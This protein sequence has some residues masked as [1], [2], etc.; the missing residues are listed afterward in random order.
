MQRC[1]EL[2]RILI[3]I[4]RLHYEEYFSGNGYYYTQDQPGY[5]ITLLRKFPRSRASAG[6]GQTQ[7]G[8]CHWASWFYTNRSISHSRN[9]KRRPSFCAH[10]FWKRALLWDDDS[11]ALDTGSFCKHR[12]DWSGCGRKEGM[13]N[14]PPGWFAV[15]FPGDGI[16]RYK[17]WHRLKLSSSIMRTRLHPPY[18]KYFLST[19]KAGTH[20]GTI[21]RQNY[22]RTFVAGFD[23]PFQH[24]SRQQKHFPELAIYLRSRWLMPLAGPTCKGGIFLIDQSPYTIASGDVAHFFQNNMGFVFKE[25]RGWTLNIFKLFDEKRIPLQEPLIGRGRNQFGLVVGK[26]K[27]SWDG[28]I[29]QDQTELNPATLLVIPL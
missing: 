13:Q 9:F 28:T 11:G 8:G 25:I 18:R 4:F 14:H 27:F 23:N 2:Y 29:R 10:S 26:K 15:S 1:I 12:C 3:S 20:I 22:G 5:G 19:V 16:T 21:E 17:K 24:F 7:G 6:R